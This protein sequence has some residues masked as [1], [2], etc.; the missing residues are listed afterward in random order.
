M[1]NI[2]TNTRALIVATFIACSSATGAYAQDAAVNSTNTSI[3]TSININKASAVELQKLKRVGP[4][5]ADRI[6]AEREGKPFKDCADAVRVR[7]VG[8]KT[9][10]AWGAA[11]VAG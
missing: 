3:N 1:R 4:A 11:C 7:G 9:I 2:K 8:A 10:E 6:I 5:L